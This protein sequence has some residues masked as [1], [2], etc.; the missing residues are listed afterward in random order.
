MQSP[1]IS[2]LDEFCNQQASVDD[3]WIRLPDSSRQFFEDL[4]LPSLHP[5]CTN[6]TAKASIFPSALPMGPPL[7]VGEV[8]SLSM[9]PSIE[10]FWDFYGHPVMAL[11]Q[12]WINLLAAYIAPLGMGYMMFWWRKGGENRKVDVPRRFIIIHT[13]TLYMSWLILTDDQYVLEFGRSYGASL[14]TGVLS[15]CPKQLRKRTLAL[16]VVLLFALPPWRLHDPS[17]YPS[18]SPGIYSNEQNQDIQIIL[19]DWHVPAYSEVATPWQFT[20]DTRTGL[21][22]LFNT[23]DDPPKFH[24]VWL[25]TEDHEYVALDVAFPRSGHD[26]NKPLYLTFHGLKRRQR[27]RICQ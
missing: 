19:K 14:L 8:D 24:R 13:T 25:E 1:W 2:Y 6:E 5:C 17:I 4:G 22:Y 15:L 10:E 3:D 9:I 26:P 21:P 20:G 16:C 12:I 11:V 27:R 7:M 23:L 18:I